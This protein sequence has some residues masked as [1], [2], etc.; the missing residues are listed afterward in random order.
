MD[1]EK[2][3]FVT[4][5]VVR[6]LVALLLIVGIF[7]IAKKTAT[8][9]QLAWLEP[10][11]SRPVL[12]YLIFLASETFVGIIPPEFYMIWSLS[13]NE[14]LYVQKVLL[15]AVLSYTGAVVAFAMGKW[16]NN[17]QL[18]QR[19][20]KR[21]KARRYTDRFEKYGGFLIF[22]SAVTPLPFAFISTI[23]GSLGYS[24]KRYIPYASARILRFAVY[25][26]IIWQANMI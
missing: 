2:K 23:S 14:W 25:G 10:L 6:A 19:L 16:L 13:E 1:G 8:E 21:K 9:E 18:V 11:T 4:K 12:M 15:L 5:S 3:R 22:I 26:W 17:T 24:F 20:L 7:I